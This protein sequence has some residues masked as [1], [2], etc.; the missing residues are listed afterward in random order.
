MM[1]LSALVGIGIGAFRGLVRPD[2]LATQQITDELRS[3]RLF[4]RSETA[5]ATVEVSP[6][7]Q[8]VTAVGL[9]R[10]G[11]WHFEGEDGFGW[12]RPLLHPGASIVREG[13][14]GSCLWLQDDNLATLQN[15]PPSFDSPYG[16]AVE[17][18]LAPEQ[19]FRPMTLLE[20]PGVWRLELDLDDELAVVLQF[21]AGEG[22]TSE[23][24][25]VVP[26]AH[27]PAD[28]FTRVSV[29]FDGRALQV[30]LDGARVGPDTV[31]DTPRRLALNPRVSLTTGRPPN[32]YRGLLDELHLSAVVRSEASELPPEVELVGPERLI[33]IDANGRLDPIW[34]RA[35]VQIAFVAGDPPQRN[36]VELGLLGTVRQFIEDIEAVVL[37]A[38]ASAAGLPGDG[39]RSE[40]AG[41]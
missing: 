12:P 26:D 10:V 38:G 8:T 31:F 15:P 2:T 13:L 3:A 29:V 23:F 39:D 21:M 11:V 6:A 41:R 5:T 19:G 37:P 7:R 22:A 4:A 17:L 1:I 16:F 35:P 27:L 14:I 30:G 32:N 18:A 40:D 36:V 24:R 9:R 34:H 20:R 25:Q 33:H 28:R